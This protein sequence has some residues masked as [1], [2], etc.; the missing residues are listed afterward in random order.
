MRGPLLAVLCW[1]SVS[2]GVT[3]APPS[4]ALPLHR[5]GLG[6]GSSSGIFLFSPEHGDH[7]GPIVTVSSS[8]ANKAA[9]DKKGAGEP[10]GG[11][12]SWKKEISQRVEQN[13]VLERFTAEGGIPSEAS[14]A[15]RTVNKSDMLGISRQVSTY[16]SIRTC[17]I[18]LYVV[19]LCRSS[20]GLACTLSLSPTTTISVLG[21]CFMLEV[22]ALHDISTRLSF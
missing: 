13:Q 5:E 21:A 17:V 10:G 12:G 14:L 18:L 6:S 19:R 20:A 7:D 15:V 3:F 11:W 22:D 8:G 4:A 1:H 16:A 9:V 2:V